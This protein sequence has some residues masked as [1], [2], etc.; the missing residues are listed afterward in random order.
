MGR[1]LRIVLY[2][3]LAGL[4]LLSSCSIKQLAMDTVIDA[5][6][7]GSGSAFTG[8]TDPELVGDALPFALKL[9]EVLLDQSPENDGLYLTTGGGYVMYANAYVQM[10]A[11]M[12]PP[13]EYDQ[14]LL[15]RNRAKSLYVRGRDYVL[16]GLDLRHPG[17]L[18]SIGTDGFDSMMAE[19]TEDDVAYLYWAGAGWLAAIAINAFDVEIG[20][21]RE[22]ALA[23]LLK[24]LE[25]DED[26]SN[27]AIH[28]VLVLYYGAMPAMLGGSEE[29]ARFH[30]DRAVEITGGKMPGPYISL[31]Q[32]VSVG[33]QDHVEF[34]SL[35]ETAIAIENDDPETRL[36]G[37]ILQNKARWL[38]E[39]I[40][41]FFLID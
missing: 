15:M 9:Y 4:L 20:I 28:E 3:A 23:L 14:R 26:Y 5:L 19:M 32:A 31:A 16:T 24:G 18:D 40:D 21:T 37:V 41:D 8:D 7:E 1:R 17:F 22:S 2:P 38:L 10:P 29:Q 25:L 27:G 30:F 12:L 35:L 6:S 11:D 39:S 34:Q 13:E 33:N 36:L